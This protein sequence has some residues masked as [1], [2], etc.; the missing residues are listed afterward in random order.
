MPKV[1]VYLP[2]DLYRAAQERKLPL[3]ALT[4]DAVERAIR[5]S[6]RKEWVSRMRALPR[7]ADVVVDSAALLDEVRAEFGE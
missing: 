3:S 2:D 7:P 6:D 1:S 5:T 4:Q